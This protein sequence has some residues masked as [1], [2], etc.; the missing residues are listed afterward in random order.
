MPRTRSLAWSELKIG[1]VAVIAIGMAVMF[2]IAVGGPGRVLVGAVRA[3]HEVSRRQGPEERRRGPRRRR[4][5]RQGGRGQADGVGGRSPAEGERGEQAAHHRP[6]ARDDRLVEP[7]RR[8]GHRHPAVHP[9]PPAAGWRL[10][11]RRARPGPAGRRRRRG[12][13]GAAAGD[14]RSCR[15]SA[16]GKGTVGKLFT[17]DQMYREVNGLIDSAG[18]RRQ[19]AGARQGHDRDD[20]SRPRGLHA[21]EFGAGLP[22]GH[23]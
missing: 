21:A 9:G 23:R 7:A 18:G 5:G 2:I 12:H 14:R 16:S 19:R 6:V 3:D 1:I 15:T 4:R 20:D 11:A 8:A 13:A 17:D 10:P 22:A